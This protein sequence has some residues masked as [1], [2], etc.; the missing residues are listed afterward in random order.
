MAEFALK[1]GKV[2]NVF[3][4]VMINV[5]A[6]DSLRTLPIAAAYG[7]SLVFYYLLAAVIFFIPTALV[8]A[9]LATAWPQTGGIY[10]WV[11]EAFGRRIAFITIWLQWIYN[12]IWYPTIMAFI[13]ATLAYLVD[14]DLANH[15]HYLLGANIVLFWTITLANCFGMRISSW[16]SVAGAI[17]GTLV[18]M[19][20]LTLFSGYAWY[21]GKVPVGALNTTSILPDLSQLNH[22]VFLVGLLFG[23]VGIEMS[24]IHAG[25]VAQPQRDYPRALLYSTVIIL[26]S[27]IFSSLAIAMVIPQSK[28]SLVSGLLDAFHIFF[29]TFDCLWLLPVMVSLIVFGSLSTTSAWIIG[30]TKGLL[31]AIKDNGCL[32]WWQKLNQHQA[33]ANILVSQAGIFTLLCSVFMLM[34]SVNSAYWILSAISAQFALLVYIFMFAAAIKLR[35]KAPLQ[36]RPYRIPWGNKGIWL[37]S[38]TG[39]TTCVGVCLIGFLPPSQIEVGN[40][41]SYEVTLITVTILFCLPPFFLKRTIA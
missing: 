34:P 23:L 37:V 14:P 6:V 22:L 12:V 5:I 40:V 21:T 38:I 29:K 30:P 36:N 7:T 15:K 27:L 26:C 35:Y 20:V 28:L 31:T 33:P 4:L 10:I 17:L 25:D 9:E 2:L 3:S 18:P 8:A 24:A 41:F 32:L 19:L 11:R 13:T 1:P 16:I 39:I